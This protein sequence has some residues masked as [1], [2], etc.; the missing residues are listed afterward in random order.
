[1][2]RGRLGMKQLLKLMRDWFIDI[3]KPRRVEMLDLIRP[4]PVY[5]KKWIQPDLPGSKTL[6]WHLLD[7]QS[8][9]PNYV[10]SPHI[11]FLFIIYTG[12]NQL[13][14]VAYFL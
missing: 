3:N 6:H 12:G 11:I 14:N 8:N 2:A 7:R 10:S 9:R 13:E 4:C 1:M 5:Q